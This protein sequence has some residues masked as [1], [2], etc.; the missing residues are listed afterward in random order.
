MEKIIKIFHS[1]RLGFVVAVIT[2]PLSLFSQGVG[3]EPSQ[4]Q[5][6]N[7][8]NSILKATLGAIDEFG[9]SIW[10]YRHTSFDGGS[11]GTSI[12]SIKC[13]NDSLRIYSGTSVFK[14]AI[15]CSKT[16]EKITSVSFN[17]TNNV[18]TVIEN[19]ISYSDT[20]EFNSSDS[21]YI[22]SVLVSDEDDEYKIIF[23]HNGDKDSIIITDKHPL[24]TVQTLTVGTEKTFNI[25]VNGST[26]ATIV[27]NTADEGLLT[28]EAGGTNSAHIHSNTTGSVNIDIAGDDGIEI[29][30]NTGISKIYIKNTGDL[31][32]DDD[33][34]ITDVLAGDVAGPM[35]AT[36][37]QNGVVGANELANTTVTAGSYTNANI[38]VDADGRVTNASNGTAPGDIT[39]VYTEDYLTG[40]GASG[41]VTIG[42]DTTGTIGVGTKFDF[43]KLD[44]VPY[45]YMGD[46]IGA[47]LENIDPSYNDT[48][49]FDYGDLASNPYNLVPY[50]SGGD[51]IGAILTGLNTT[52]NDTLIFDSGDADFWQ[53]IV[54]GSD[55][56][57]T[58]SDF[59]FIFEPNDN[60]RYKIRCE[61][62]LYSADTTVGVRPIFE[63]D[64]SIAGYTDY[65]V[66]I[67][68][69][70]GKYQNLVTNGGYNTLTWTAAT[71]QSS[72]H[73]MTAIIE[74]TLFTGTN[75]ANL[76]IGFS[77]ETGA[78][79]K[80]KKG[81]LFSYKTY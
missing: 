50:V 43:S 79:V 37:I 64:G 39:G 66:S 36:Q 59:P 24:V 63:I 51:T 44:L 42:I 29:T 15:D 53:H 38:T 69:P 18:L 45:V 27:T 40:G 71:T 10:V 21:V 28:V 47:I 58:S 19:G 61:L 8:K 56:T 16:N 34:K 70:N 49:L 6:S 5:A 23:D 60:T 14:T 46:T 52:S 65:S 7:I 11:G 17:E 75:P 13:V 3:I 25:K 26:I 68:A 41:A 78:S 80:M 57:T 72:G 9:D 73:T 35:Y 12:D 81:S 77:S 76:T 74:A 1:F 48:L 2:L 54:L 62:L 32:P 33:W 30:E 55:N 22:K 31:D 4:L 67:I 20:I